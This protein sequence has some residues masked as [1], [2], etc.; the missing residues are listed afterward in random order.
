M[1]NFFEKA[2][3]FGKSFMLPIAVLPA[4]GLLLGIGGALSNPNT[5]STYPFLDVPWLQHVFT[6]MSSAGSIVFANLALL[7][8]IGVAVGLA[9]SDKGTAGLAAGL[10]YLVMNAT[11]S[12]M[13]V[14][15]GNLAADNLASVGQGM[16]L[17]I[18]TLETGVFGGVIVGLVTSILH[19]RYNKIQ[20]PQFLGFFG[21]SRFIPIVTSFAAIFVGVVM[22]FVWPAIQSVIFQA[23]GLVEATGYIGT[24]F[25]GFIL[26]LLGPL[27][28][29]HIFY[30]PFWTTGLGGSMEVGGQLVE[31][32]QKIFFAQLADP[33]T[34]KFFI[35]TA[36][37][38]SGRFI[39]MMFGLLGA[40]LAIYHTAKPEKKKVVF[41]LML[42]AALTSFLTGIT[43]PLE[44]SFLFIAPFLYV[45]H[46]FF[47]GLAFMLAHIFQI[48][49]G[50]TFSGGLIDFILFGMLQGQAKTNWLMV[51]VIGVV[52]F[53][54]YYFTFRFLIVR[55]NL[56]TPGR[57]EE[58][59]GGAAKGGEASAE[60]ASAGEARAQA[61]LQALGGQDNIKDLDCCATR[62]RVSVF[63]VDGVQEDKLKETGAK[64]V[65]VKG[66][67]VQVIYGP[68]V[69]IIKNEIEEYM[70]ES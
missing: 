40:A 25:Y 21:G 32:T 54:L 6:I 37:F 50:Q 26:R 63:Q 38:M 48:T 67:G 34:E 61:V 18:Q 31:G 13:L 9:R 35:G 65:I 22:Y 24:L 60:A 47:D 28:L 39:T 33:S 53:C 16:V 62:L 46:A 43:E 69:T 4:A 30:M 1:N 52:W 2:Q 64:G 44:F 57:E 5:V 55:F 36:R 42:S 29:H 17:G 51:P 68:Q 70:G 41:G 12:A 59:V 8:A 66:N 15:T 23:G 7:F 19:N 11:I 14:I 27:G 58:A 10:G 56:R 45:I 49:I 3:R 20:L